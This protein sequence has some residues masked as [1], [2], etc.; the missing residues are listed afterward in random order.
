MVR[1]KFRY[2]KK[3]DSKDGSQIWMSVVVSGQNNKENDEFFKWTP[4]GQL[5]MGT[6]NP[7]AAKQFEQGKEYYLD[8][9]PAS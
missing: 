4:S 3:E 8:F 6:I 1:A 2:D 5:T 9:T 7:E